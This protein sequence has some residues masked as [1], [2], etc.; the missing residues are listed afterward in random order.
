MR[1]AGILGVVACV[2]L[3]GCSAPPAPAPTTPS[4]TPPGAAQPTPVPS[5]AGSPHACFTSSW[6]ARGQFAVHAERA[7]LN[8]TA[9]DAP[10]EKFN[11]TLK[12]LGF[13]TERG[14]DPYGFLATRGSERAELRPLRNNW[15]M[16]L[17][18]STARDAGQTNAQGLFEN[19][20]A[21]TGYP[22]NGTLDLRPQTV[23]S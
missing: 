8:T 20:S 10:R 11:A 15:S 6:S 3:A 16:V 21:G 9:H 13:L 14:S 4:A 22:W 2:V 1:A 23:C 12:E 19:V 5:P 18:W 17:T 7:I